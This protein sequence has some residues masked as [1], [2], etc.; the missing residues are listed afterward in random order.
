MNLQDIGFTK[1]E[2]Q[3]RVV[4]QL[5]GQVMSTTTF[6]DIGDE[7]T[8]PSDLA[9]Q[10]KGLVA[11]QVSATVTALAEKHILPNVS[12]YIETLTLQE[13][14]SWGE[15]TGEPITF[16]E[17]LTARAEAYMQEKVDFDGKSKAESNG[18]SWSGKQTR[19]TNLIHRHLQYSI[20]AAMKDALKIATG[21]I[22]TGIQ[23]TVK[24]QLGEISKTLK[25]SVSVK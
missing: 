5:C 14:N 2:L 15:R 4:D 13:T 24:I 12:G 23:E 22:V 21:S 9:K 17:Y 8:F 6:D 18:Y 3:Q 25:T 16:I 20:E 7:V 11:E 10:L 1:E 19:I